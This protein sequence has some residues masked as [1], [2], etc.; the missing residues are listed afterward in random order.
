MRVIHSLPISC[1]ILFASLLG[2]QSARAECLLRPVAYV[3]SQQ[4]IQIIFKGTPVSI[5]PVSRASGVPTEKQQVSGATELRDT[6]YSAPHGADGFRLIFDVERIW[7]GS[8]GKRVE[9]YMD[10]GSENPSFQLGHSSPVFVKY[11]VDPEK[12]RL[13]GFAGND[14]LVFI[15]AECTDFSESQVTA[16]LGPGEE[17]H[18]TSVP[19]EAHRR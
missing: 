10:R 16:V 19:P 13:L 7:K 17:P 2:V 6:L 9:V 14:T 1:T 11:L 5:T 4:D 18:K 12:R 3:A 15:V 8:A